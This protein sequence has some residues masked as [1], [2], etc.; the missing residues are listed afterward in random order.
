LRIRNERISN[1]F[2]RID[3]VE[4]SLL[5]EAALRDA[6]DFFLTEVA[7]FVLGAVLACGSYGGENNKELEEGCSPIGKSTV[8]GVCGLDVREIGEESIYGVDDVDEELWP[9]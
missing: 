1:S 6:L 3:R 4:E 2:Q 8:D 9:S 5:A 7:F